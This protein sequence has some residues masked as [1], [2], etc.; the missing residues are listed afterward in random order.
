MERKPIR[1]LGNARDLIDVLAEHGPLTPAE[2]AQLTGI[3]RPSVY[4]LAD[5][6]SVIGLVSPMPDS[7]FTLGLR[8]L[9]L[10][11][12]AFHGMA[13]WANAPRVLDDITSKTE[14]TAF[15][16]LPRA[17]EAV[18]IAWSPGSGIGVL[19][20]KP[21]RALPLYLGAGGR[22]TLAAHPD[23]EQYLAQ[24]PFPR[25]T[26]NTL[27]E[28]SELRADIERTREQ[29]Y[30]HSDEDATIGIGA[31]GVPVTDDRGTFLACVSLAGTAEYIRSH[32]DP[33]LAVLRDSARELAR[34]SAP[35]SNRPVD[36]TA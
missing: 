3:P 26:A 14:Q 15:L 33:L 1:V 30:V 2:I 34:S 20:L 13:E 36:Q 22:V 29:G 23:P 12:T 31:L 10:A 35:A 8:W 21:G 17:D 16:T 19:I 7:R 25:V 18:C 24:A 6:L 32:R 4:R 27:V 9:H 5:G 28:A 11:D